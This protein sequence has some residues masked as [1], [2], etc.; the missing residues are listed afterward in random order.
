MQGISNPRSDRFA[1]LFINY[2]LLLFRHFS[3]SFHMRRILYQKFRMHFECVGPFRVLTLIVKCV[4]I[5]ECSLVGWFL[6]PLDSVGPLGMEPFNSSLFANLFFFLSFFLLFRSLFE[7]KMNYYWTERVWLGGV[8][9]FMY[10]YVFF[11]FFH[12]NSF[13]G[14]IIA[15]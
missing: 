7:T 10:S 11:F 12:W 4:R 8:H 15:I 6:L 3:L 1:Y 9:V 13:I 5:W 14:S 2:Y